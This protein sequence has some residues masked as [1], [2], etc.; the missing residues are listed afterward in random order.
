MAPAGKESAQ[1][2]PFFSRTSGN[3][4]FRFTTGSYMSFRYPLNGNYQQAL[5]P[6]AYEGLWILIFSYAN[7]LTIFV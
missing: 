5:Y 3:A 6:S 2:Y 4:I 7:I 1:F